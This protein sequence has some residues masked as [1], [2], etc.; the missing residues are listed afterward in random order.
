MDGQNEGI[1]DLLTEITIEPQVCH[2]RAFDCHE[3][4]SSVACAAGSTEVGEA[5]GVEG[6]F[7]HI[8]VDV[9]NVDDTVVKI[10]H[11]ERFILLQNA[12][13]CKK[14][15]DGIRHVDRYYRNTGVRVNFQKAWLDTTYQDG[16]ERSH[17]SLLDILYAKYY[18]VVLL[19]K[20]L[21]E[22]VSNGIIGFHHESDSP[23]LIEADNVVLNIAVY[24]VYQT[25]H[26]LRIT[27]DTHSRTFSSDG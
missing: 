19:H 23:L 15:T 2:S 1:E 11:V 4:L 14:H 9:I 21:A 5:E 18:V 16:K 13:R 25:F 17:H 6:I 22:A 24:P 7:Q 26:P 12:I 8:P 20:L 27:A 10:K 3:V